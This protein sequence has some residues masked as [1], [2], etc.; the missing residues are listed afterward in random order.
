MTRNGQKTHHVT[1]RRHLAAT[2]M[3]KAEQARVYIGK[4][5]PVA[6][7]AP[8]G[9]AK[10]YVMTMRLLPS[11]EKVIDYVNYTDYTGHLKNKH[12]LNAMKVPEV[13]TLNAS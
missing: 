4:I 12:S 6:Y 9:V 8:R 1:F 10:S 7:V 2:H 11:R 13:Y 3:L 5:I